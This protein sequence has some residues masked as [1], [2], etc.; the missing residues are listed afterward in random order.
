MDF[1]FACPLPR[2]AIVARDSSFVRDSFR[3]QPWSR[4]S[5]IIDAM[6]HASAK[7]QGLR[8]PITSYEKL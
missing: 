8:K 2:L 7:A 3:A 4:L 5:E 1:A 6:G